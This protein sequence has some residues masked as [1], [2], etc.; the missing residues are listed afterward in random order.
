V[1]EPLQ[2][3]SK[4]FVPV[5]PFSGLLLRIDGTA[6]RIDGTA[7]R[8]DSIPVQRCDPAAPMAF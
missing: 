1:E 3:G 6:L 2:A 7:L 4:P 8:V 5:P